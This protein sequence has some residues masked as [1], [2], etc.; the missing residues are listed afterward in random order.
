MKK[1][2]LL[3]LTFSLIVSF[4]G[5]FGSAHARL[6]D[7]CTSA[8]ASNT[9]LES[10]KVYSCQIN[11]PAAGTGFCKGACGKDADC[12]N[13]ATLLGW[14]NVKCTGTSG[15]NG[16]CIEAVVAGKELG[17]G[18]QKGSELLAV[19][20]ALIDWL[21]VLLLITATIF[22]ILAAFQFITGGGDATKVSEARQKLLYAIIAV[23]VAAFAKGIPVVIK[24]IVAI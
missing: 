14:V 10:G 1:L 21:F 3:L 12:N 13:L 22:I 15:A 2:V 5:I 11:D 20:N 4:A 7:V 17:K 16:S 9:C 6:G 18:P 24:A 23:V 8:D 19:L